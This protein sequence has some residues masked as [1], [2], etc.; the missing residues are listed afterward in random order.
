MPGHEPRPDPGADDRGDEARVEQAADGEGADRGPHGR[1]GVDDPL[2][3]L[4]DEAEAEHRDR[5]HGA[6]P[7]REAE[8][9]G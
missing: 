5:R 1:Q 9:L 7:H 3:S 6:H 4:D 8:R 2:R